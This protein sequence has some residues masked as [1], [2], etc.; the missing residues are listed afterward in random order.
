MVVMRTSTRLD[1]AG[2]GGLRLESCRAVASKRKLAAL[3]VPATPK[4][5]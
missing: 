3:D 4:T 2:I 1:R 5:R